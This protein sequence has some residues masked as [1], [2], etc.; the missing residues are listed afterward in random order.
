MNGTGGHSQWRMTGR[1][2]VHAARL[3]GLGHRGD[4]DARERS[5][6]EGSPVGS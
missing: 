3:D 6:G 5:R 4:I 2:D 1:R